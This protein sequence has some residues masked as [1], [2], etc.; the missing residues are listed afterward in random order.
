[1]S[2]SAR[3]LHIAFVADTV[4]GKLGGGVVAAHHVVDALRRRHK[5]TV[6]A[7][8]ATGADDLR[9]PGFQLPL[10]S[11]HEMQFTMARPDRPAMA[12][13]FEEVDVVHVQFP[14]WLGMAAVD[15]AHRAHRP[16]VTAF[17]VQPENILSNVGVRWPW[18][19][20]RIY[21]L[22]ASRY[23]GPAD[24]IVAPTEFAARKLRENGVTT[25]VHVISNG[26]PPDL[27]T[28]AT[29]AR[30]PNQGGPFLVLAVGRLAAE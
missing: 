2:K 21:A 30:R 1:M 28:L 4:E 23:F 14:F 27:S 26:V 12:R 16:V 17:H 24:A 10:R 8:D 18:L 6:V 11:M 9:V 22:W 5:V 20:R 15:E 3:R 13:L 29:K 25:P 7:S 19:A